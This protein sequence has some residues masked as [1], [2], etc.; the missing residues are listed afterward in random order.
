[1]RDWD[2]EIEDIFSFF[3]LLNIESSL[4]GDFYEI[5]YW[6]FS[7]VGSGSGFW[8]VSNFSASGSGQS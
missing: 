1:M 8:S 6:E 5:E 2:R 4:K 7:R 3:Y